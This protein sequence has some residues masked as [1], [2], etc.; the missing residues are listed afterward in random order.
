MN[1]TRRRFTVAA[2]LA[3]G[4]LF[5][6]LLPAGPRSPG[7]VRWAL[8]LLAV[9][10]AM[11]PAV[12]RRVS[13]V[14]E[15]LRHP[16]PRALDWSTLLVGVLAAA[17]FLLTAIVQDRDL[18]P[19]THDEQSYLLQMQM[20]ARGR[21]WMPQ[22]ELADFF[23]TF[24]VIVRPVYAS[25]YFPG[26]A[27][28]HVPTVW[29]DWP[30]WLMP[31]VASGAVVALLYRVVTELVDGA[32][33]AMA[34]LLLVSLTEFRLLTVLLFSAVPT[35]LLGLL[36]VWA[37][38]RWHRSGQLPWLLAVGVFAGWAAITRPVDAVCYALPV[39]VATLFD[40]R[41]RPAK[42]WAIAAAL[43]VL[44]AAPFLALQAVFNKGVTGSFTHMP[45]T[46]YH[47]RDQPNTSF[48]FR[49]Y[50]PSRQPA[51]VVQQKGDYYR[52]FILPF[53]ESH[54]PARVL[55][56][57]WK[58][59]LPRLFDTT[60]PGRPLLVLLPVALLGLTDRRRVVLWATL[61]L[62]LLL[63][64]FNPF[65]LEHYAVVFAPAVL[66]SVVLGMQVAEDAFP[67][68]R[69]RIASAFALAVVA[70]SLTSLYEL[71]S[72][73]TLLDRTPEARRRHAVSDEPFR[74][75]LLRYVHYD[76]GGQVSAPAVVLFR[77]TPGDPIVE[78]PVYNSGVAWPD[79]APII[80]AHDL[81]ERNREIFAYYARHQPER[82][83]WLFDRRTGELKKLGP[84]W[85][86][87]AGPAS[88]P[89][90]G[91]SP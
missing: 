24:W 13:V 77:Y 76:F 81:G 57:W 86:L 4:G 56:T 18:F 55:P 85:A 35:M 36:I 75:R 83:F 20:L 23:D 84:A 89:G 50:D 25:M 80:R 61:P 15:K 72:L 33:G 9:A 73:T 1:D 17:Y 28:F 22:H 51:S 21:L 37:Y 47:D 39:G 27:L 19:K 54:Q 46:Y 82:V 6:L 48:G 26:N 78:E 90:A 30:T 11:V 38:L 69:P 10:L 8:L 7:P 66:L 58:T 5:W 29:F 31:L 63:Y 32:A 40:L 68:G 62:F 49:P 52:D 43:I 65:F 59:Y 60:L 3:A 74:S 45:H 67:R 2:L 34:A 87:A 91:E 64:F 16:S 44:G 88:R 41:R 70:L 71:N 53:L 79:D 12:H 42:H 14:L